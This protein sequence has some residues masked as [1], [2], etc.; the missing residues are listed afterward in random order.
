[1]MKMVSRQYSITNDDVSKI[2]RPL[3]LECFLH[4]N[5]ILLVTFIIMV[6]DAS[7]LHHA[8]VNSVL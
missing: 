3:L 5:D 2:L 7:M 6:I 8:C 4:D 1:M